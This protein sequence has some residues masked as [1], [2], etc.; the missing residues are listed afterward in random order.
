MLA[1]FHSWGNLSSFRQLSRIIER[2][3][4]IEFS[5]RF[6]AADTKMSQRRRK[7][8]LILVSKTSLI[9]LKW[10]S[11]WP[12]FKASSKH[13]PGDVLKMS[14]RTHPQDIF[15]ETFLTRLPRHVLKISLGPLKTSRLFLVRGNGHLET[16]YGLSIYVLFKLLTYYLSITRQTNWMNLNKLNMLNHGNNIEIMKT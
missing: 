2:G 7:N 13:L 14:S 5:H 11:R 15:R 12:F 9:G 16:I 10:K 1:I 4:Q 6:I 8:V 3:L